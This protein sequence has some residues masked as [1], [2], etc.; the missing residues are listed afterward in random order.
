M[1]FVLITLLPFLVLG[2]SLILRRH[3]N[4]AISILLLLA[5]LAIMVNAIFAFGFG[6][7]TQE[8]IP[9]KDRVYSNES[10]YKQYLRWERKK[11]N[12]QN[13]LSFLGWA[14]LAANIGIIVINLKK[15]KSHR[16]EEIISNNL[17]IP[18][19]LKRIITNVPFT[20][21]S[22]LPIHNLKVENWKMIQNPEGQKLFSVS[23]FGKLEHSK[24]VANSE[25]QPEKIII[26][27]ILSKKEYLLF[28]AAIHGIGAVAM[29][30]YSYLNNVDR[31]ASE[32]Y[33]SK[34]G[35]V[36]FQLFIAIYYNNT[37]DYFTPESKNGQ[38]KTISGQEIDLQE[39]IANGFD[40]FY[41]Y[42]MDKKG[43]LFSIFEV[44]EL[45]NR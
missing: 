8:E 34:N 10:E 13:L 24:I 12:T 1:L 2:Q 38:Y 21:V 9:I 6:M 31:R 25:D 27:D 11:R 3:I 32:I 4:A 30:D 19:H 14:T 23:Y 44:D 20:Y 22:K 33:M 42:A 35:A 5:G 7:S 39:A 37:V 15:G 17:P 29:T 43:H 16:Y 26:T 36:V 40:G 45:E 18:T 41:L 28:D